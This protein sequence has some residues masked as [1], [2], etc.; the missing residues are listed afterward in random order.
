RHLEA[1]PAQCPHP[2]PDVWGHL[3]GYFS[4]R[5]DSGRNRLR[6]ARHWPVDLSRHCVSRFPGGPG[7]G[8]AHRWYGDCREPAGRY[9]LCLCRSPDPLWLRARMATGEL[10]RE[11]P[12]VRPGR[13]RLAALRRVPVVPLSIIALMVLTA[14]LANV[15]TPYSPVDI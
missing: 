4:D 9:S 13:W 5:G 1:R 7:G 14:V 11:E 3:S 6:L 12:L 15:L 2:R 10:V 8:V